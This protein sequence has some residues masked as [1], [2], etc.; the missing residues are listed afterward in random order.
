MPPSN[1]RKANEAQRDARILE[2]GGQKAVQM[3]PVEVEQRKVEIE[4]ARVDVKEKDLEIQAKHQEIA[5]DLQIALAQIQAG[6][7]VQIAQAQS[8]GNALGKA[9]M[10]IWGDPGTFQQMSSAFLKGQSFVQTANGMISGAPDGVRETLR[11]IGEIGSALIKQYTGKDVSPQEVEDVIKRSAQDGSQ[12]G[13]RDGI[14]DNGRKGANGS[15][16]GAP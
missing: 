8:M 6:K 12:N 9:N 1:Q 10:T 3:V 14:Q 5:K 7:E 15:T 11:N 13:S 16:S 4:S 2:A